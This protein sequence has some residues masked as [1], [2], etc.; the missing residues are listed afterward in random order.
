MD[1]E[2]QANPNAGPKKLTLEEY[3]KR[4]QPKS[5]TAKEQPKP[6]PQQPKRRRAGKQVKTRQELG[7]LHRL[8]QLSVNK[9]DKKGFLKKINQ[10]KQ[11]R[12]IEKTNR[13]INKRRQWA[14][15][16]DQTRK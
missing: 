12:K 15:S 5:T 16:G 14:G 8:A 4:Q 13:K 2:L 3:R 1:K 11:R 9:E 7:N 10:I 6:Q